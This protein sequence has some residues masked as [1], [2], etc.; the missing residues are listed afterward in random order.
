[1][2]NM[3]FDVFCKKLYISLKWQTRRALLAA[4][5]V[6]KA[7]KCCDV[8]RFPEYGAGPVGATASVGR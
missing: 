4:P 6:G 5:V 8:V 3:N 2:I 7:A 1:M